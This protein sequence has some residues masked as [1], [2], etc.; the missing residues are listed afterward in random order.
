MTKCFYPAFKEV[1]E[2]YIVIAILVQSRFS[3]HVFIIHSKVL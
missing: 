3:F 2:I 1:Y